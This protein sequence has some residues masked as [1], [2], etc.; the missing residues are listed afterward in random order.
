V[1]VV[2]WPWWR[3]KDKW[4]RRKKEWRWDGCGSNECGGNE[5]RNCWCWLK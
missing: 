2:K 1:M 4:W 5:R 3:W